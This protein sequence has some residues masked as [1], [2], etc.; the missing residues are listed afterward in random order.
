MNIKKKP[1]PNNVTLPALINGECEIPEILKNFIMN[2]ICSHK[3]T[4]DPFK[5]SKVNAIC[6]DIIYCA[7]NGDIKPAKNIQ[8]GNNI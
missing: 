3:E 5:I 1:V 6:S 8:L 4:N 2:C 7:T